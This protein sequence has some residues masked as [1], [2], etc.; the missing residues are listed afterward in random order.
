MWLIVLSPDVVR[1]PHALVM[2]LR[3][4]EIA[5]VA[6]VSLVPKRELRMEWCMPIAQVK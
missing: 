3:I 2:E 6:L 1:T 4:P 5:L